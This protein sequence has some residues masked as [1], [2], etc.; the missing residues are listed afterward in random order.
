VARYLAG[1]S[2]V[3]AIHDQHILAMSTTEMTLTCHLVMLKGHPG[4]QLVEKLCHQLYDKFKIMHS[5]LQ[6]EL[7]DAGV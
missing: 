7:G 2:G 3:D 5:T 4:D 6:F 1:L